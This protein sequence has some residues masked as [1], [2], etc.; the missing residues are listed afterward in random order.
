MPK[1]AAA[2]TASASAD[3][4]GGL[5]VKVGMRSEPRTIN[6][7]PAAVSHLGL[8]VEQGESEEAGARAQGR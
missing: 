5:R 2:V 3:T 4:S 8:V 1:K 6:S 7:T